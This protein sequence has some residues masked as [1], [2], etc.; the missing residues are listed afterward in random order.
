MPP[1]DILDIRAIYCGRLSKNASQLKE[2]IANL[3]SSVMSTPMT[4]WIIAGLLTLITI[5]VTV[6]P[7]FAKTQT[8]GSSL[9]YDKEIYKSRLL[10]IEADLSL[11]KVTKGEYEYTLAEEGR[12]FL[13]LANADQPKNTFVGLSPSR[14]ATI[15]AFTAIILIPLIA[16]GSY[17]RL[18]AI[19]TPD[20]PLIAR[21]NADPGGQSIQILLQRAESQLA[22]NPADGRGWL[23]VAPVYMR[24]NRPRDAANAFRNAIRIL[25]PTAELQTQLG[26]ALAVS[27]GGVITEEARLL[28]EQ[29]AASDP[30]NTKPQFFLA[31]ALN[32]AGQFE[33]AVIAWNKVIANSPPDAP[34][35]NIA[36][37]Q[38]KLAQEKISPDAPGNPTTED[39]KAASELS[40]TERQDFI[41]SMVDRLA[42]ELED[43][44]QNKPGWRRIIRSLTV[45]KRNDDALEA[46]ETAMLVFKDDAEFLAELEEIKLAL[47]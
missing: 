44:P 27:D 2:V 25:G 7:V 1:G 26:E 33:E 38:L 43:N 32:Q 39:I 5:V 30:S 40:P 3:V 24:L 8:P 17:S 15:G 20:Q 18:G 4:F 37:Q 22:K 16:I 36:R 35:V 9:D 21:L 42:G 23:V 12:R 46:I 45:L 19:D 28:F 11:G 10:E 47:N 41:N 34:W 31:I 13:A 6:L 14:S 29:A